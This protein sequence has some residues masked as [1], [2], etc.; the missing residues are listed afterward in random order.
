[1]RSRNPLLRAGLT[2][3]VMLVVAA[4]GV[5]VRAMQANG[6][7]SSVT[8]GFAGSCK[9][10][11]VAGVGDIEVDAADNVAFFAVLE[12]RNPKGPQDG[13]YMLNLSGPAKLEK[14]SGTP[15]DFHPR[16]LSLWRGPDG[17]LLLAAVNH[18]SDDKFSVDTFKLTQKDGAWTLAPQGTVMGGLL[19]DPQDVVLVAANNFYVSNSVTAK[20][21]PMRMLQANGVLPGGNIVYFNGTVLREVV[22]GLYGPRGLLA[23]RD[24]GHLLVSSLTGRSI[25]AL[26]RESF[27]GNLSEGESLDLPAGGDQ[28][29]LDGEGN[30][31]VAGH[32]KLSPW[33]AMGRDPS[34]RAPSQLFKVTM[35]GSA[36]QSVE[37][38]YANDGNPLAG[39]ETGAVW[40]KRLL[41]GSPLE[42]K[43]LDCEMAK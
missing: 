3:V 27:T 28:M 25:M 2:I 41:L 18:R 23:T 34:S 6:T 9:S 31:W 21:R 10:L 11:P 37:Q 33:R 32:A 12:A 20:R 26:N 39:A 5:T 8:P 36:P 43:L 14:L 13:I 42:A 35:K 19:A 40:G 22:N 38:V 7:F 24:G 29:A 4:G 17:V 1:M 16:S 30:V 15:A